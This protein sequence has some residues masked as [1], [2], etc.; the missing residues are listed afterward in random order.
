MPLRILLVKVLR[1]NLWNFL[2]KWGVRRRRKQE[3][4]KKPKKKKVTTNDSKPSNQTKK[5]PGKKSGGGGNSKKQKPVSLSTYDIVGTLKPRELN[6]KEISEISDA[7]LAQI[8]TG[9]AKKF[10]YMTPT[11]VYKGP[12]NLVLQ[13]DVDILRRALY[14]IHRM[15]G[16]G[17]KILLTQ[18]LV[19][20]VEGKNLYLCSDF[21]GTCDKVENWDVEE[22]ELKTHDVGPVPIVS[23][24]SVGVIQLSKII[25]TPVFDKVI[26]DAIVDLA[27][28]Y[29]IGSG[30]SQLGN[31]IVSQDGEKVVAIDIEENKREYSSM[32]RWQLFRTDSNGMLACKGK[33]S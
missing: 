22:K 32:D 6:E 8:P 5:K 1:E 19:Y 26:G 33:E 11:K 24:E 17:D 14:R 29:L 13:R 31:I 4:E 3:E 21:I 27:A 25:Q 28:R 18:E 9:K 23:R 20:D 16:W 10:I 12:F 7:P 15:K 30:D 2:N